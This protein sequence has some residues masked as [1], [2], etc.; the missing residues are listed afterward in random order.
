MIEKDMQKPFTV[1]DVTTGEEADIYEIA[2]R[3]EWAKGL[4]Y[5]DMNGFGINDDGTLILIDECGNYV[6][7]PSGRFM[8]IWNR[9]FETDNISEY[10]NRALYNFER[11]DF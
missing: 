5:C 1:I 10:I 3:E 2:L 9:D 11:G 8:V 7:C 6:Y 4:M